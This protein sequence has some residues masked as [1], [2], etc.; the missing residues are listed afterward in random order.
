VPDKLWNDPTVRDVLAAPRTTNTVG[1]VE[2]E[3]PFPSPPDW[4]DQWI[5]F[6]LVDRF[7]NVAG[8]PVGGFPCDTYQGGTFEGIAACLPYLRDLGVGAI[9]I[10]P[11][12]MNPQW[13]LGYWGGYGATDLLRIEPRF[14]AD[15]ARARSD[16]DY[17]DSQFRAL[18]DAIHAH[19]MYVILDIVL[20]HLGDLFDYEGIGDEA[21]YKPKPEDPEYEIRWRD[22]SGTPRNDWRSVADVQN[23]PRDAGPWPRELQRNDFFR[24]RGGS[25]NDGDF[26]RLRELVTEYQTT[27]TGRFPV[28][29]ILIRAYQYLIARFDLDGFRIDTLKY[30]ER[31]FARVFGNAM[32][33]YALSIGKKNF[34]TFGEV[35]DNDDESA[36]ARY[37]G[38]H[39]DDDGQSVGVDAALDFPVFHRLNEVIKDEAPPSVFAAH[40]QQRRDVL[41][42]V[43]SSHGE[44]SRYYVT[45]LDNHDLNGRFHDPQ[46]PARTPLALT[47][48][49]TLQGIPCIYYGTEQGLSGSGWKREFVR[50]ALWGQPHPF[51]TQHELYQRIRELSRLRDEN[52]ALRYGRQYHR[53]VSGNGVDFAYSTYAGGVIAYSRILNDREVLVVANTSTTVAQLLHVVVDK[54]LNPTGSR[55]TVLSSTN[56]APVA[57]QPTAVHGARHTVRVQLAPVEAQVLGRV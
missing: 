3:Y 17:A 8:P 6:L 53:E 38:K 47:C 33:E 16:P 56:T 10:S 34:F 1:S 24:R 11:V 51:D 49:M 36:I 48:L 4:R 30:V 13:F 25:Q 37:V 12:L 44:A 55:W 45:F 43:V 27:E 41:R 32:R 23:L 57:P 20:N 54:A 26:S 50:E 28:R 42:R 35:W 5:Y 15:P 22:G 18:V 29:D 9:W 40:D 39:T 21:P 46:H 52:P 7:N 14:C 19:D 2:I 31:E